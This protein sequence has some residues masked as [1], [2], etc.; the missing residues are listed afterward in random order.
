MTG[1]LICSLLMQNFGPNGF[2]VHL[3]LFLFPVVIYGL[4]RLSQRGLDDNPDSTF[5][6]L[7]RD[8]TPLGIELD[9]STGVNLSNTDN[10]KK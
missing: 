2:F 4:Y 10:V 1:P 5:T 9:P 3:I 8:I 6:P 7:P